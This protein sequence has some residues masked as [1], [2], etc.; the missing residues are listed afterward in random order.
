MTAKALIRAGGE[1]MLGRVARTL[2]ATPSVGRI[3][4]LAQDA[5]ALLEGDLAWM[6]EEPRIATAEAGDGISASVA[7]VAGTAAAP[8]PVLATTADHPLLTSQMIEAFIAGALGADAA[9]AMVERKTIERA[10]PDTRRTWL[11]AADGHYSGANLF[12]FMTPSA[13]SGI[14]FWARAEKDRKRTLKLLSYLGLGTFLRA[15][16]R[17]ISLEAAAERAGR[18]AGIQLKAVTLPFAEAAIDV[19]KPADL[20]LVER[21][22]VDRARSPAAAAAAAAAAARRPAA[23]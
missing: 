23:P 11:K 14:E 10:H 20:A 15:V 3:V 13:R 18:K 4:V 1:P 21:I 7:A 19:D 5:D 9:F 22:L 6:A 17:T 16:T 8:Y 2:L 12:A